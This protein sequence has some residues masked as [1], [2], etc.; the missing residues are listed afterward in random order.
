MR[1]IW[2]ALA[3]AS[4]LHMTYIGIV[5]SIGLLQTYFYKPQFSTETMVLQSEV[6]FG[7]EAASPI[8]YLGSFVI[9]AMLI[10]LV[11]IGRKQFNKQ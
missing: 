9:V 6:S 10:A 1:I 3:G 2:Q 5:F 7:S 8:I 11:L 4:A